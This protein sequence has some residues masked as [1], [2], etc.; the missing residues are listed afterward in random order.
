MENKIITKEYLG[1]AIEF[2][3]VNGSV[4]ANANKMAEGFG[5]SQKLAD[6][7][8]S[9]NTKKYI[10]VLGKHMENS[11]M[12]ILSD[13]TNVEYG[14]GTWIHEKLVLSFARYCSTEFE[15]WC[16]EQIETLLREGS[17]SLDSKQN[18]LLT[19]IQSPTEVERA[20]ALNRYELEYVKPL[21]LENKQQKS[22]I[23]NVVH[24]EKYYITPTVIG[25]KFGMSAKKLNNILQELG[26]QY[27]K[28]NKWC[29]KSDYYG[30][31]D[32]A[33]FEKPNK[34]WEKGSS[35]RYSNEGE[36][37]L[38]KLLTANGYEAV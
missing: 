18:L 13:K 38:Y 24:N 16:D 1:S 10:E 5:G 21:E 15:L 8:R 33:Y 6:W 28:G 11:H 27:K 29:L 3:I 23:D 9:Q 20:V 35:L 12:L 26:V 32:Y 14:G 19:I 37:I 36:R 2:K 25:N 30:I 31:G 22:Y 7:K 34:E 17:V 4:Y